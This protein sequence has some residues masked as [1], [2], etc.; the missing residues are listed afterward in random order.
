[1]EHCTKEELI[2]FEKDIANIFDQGK[3][4]YLIHLSGGNEDQLIEIF[5]EVKEGDY[6]FS[7]HRSHYHYLLAGGSPEGLK[8]RILTGESMFVFDKKINFLSSSIV[9]GT[10][11]IATGVAMALKRKGSQNK[12]WC[13]VG[14]GAEDEGHFYEAARY[15]DGWD[16][17][18]TFVI[19]DN[20][21]SVN[22][23][24]ADRYGTS[25]VR[26]PSCVK[27]YKYRPTYPHG[28]TGNWAEIIETPQIKPPFEKRLEDSIKPSLEIG[29]FATR[30]L[31]YKESIKLSMEKLAQ[32]ENVLFVGYNIIHDSAYGT[33]KDIPREKRIECPLAENLMTGIAMGLS[34]EGFLP[35]LFFER[36]DFTLVGLDA[37][38]NHMDKIERLS[39]GEFRMPVIIRVVV[40]SVRPTYAGI[41]H[42]QNFCAGFKEI[43]HMPIYELETSQEVLDYYSK[44]GQTTSPVMLIE[45]K[46]FYGTDFEVNN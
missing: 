15:V 6:I 27:K 43:L 5:K 46:E 12:V 40:G 31:N 37:I 38:A 26:W 42:T 3:I 1:M 11:A 32:Q 21:R 36:C 2:D 4:P 29:S 16:L 19:E 8:E 25:E 20:D 14:D 30:S 7:T 28:G 41:T 17:P 34:L 18:C 33:L 23:K 24:K 45:K 44:F 22:T 9:A 35:V 39:G 13:F 10:P